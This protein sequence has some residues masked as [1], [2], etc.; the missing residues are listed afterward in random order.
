MVCGDQKGGTNEKDNS[1]GLSGFVFGSF[2]IL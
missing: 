1:G 2:Y